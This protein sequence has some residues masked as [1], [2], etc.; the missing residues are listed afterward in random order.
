MIYALVF[1]GQQL[2]LIARVDRELTS[3]FPMLRFSP[4]S[5]LLSLLCW[6]D[7]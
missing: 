3:N 2:I 1:L 5:R 7:L 6:R 4:D